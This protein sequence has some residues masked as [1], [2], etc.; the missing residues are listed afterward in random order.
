MA[1]AVEGPQNT[2]PLDLCR[3]Q[4]ETLVSR[5]LLVLSCHAQ[6]IFQK[7]KKCSKLSETV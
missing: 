6:E 2:V 1:L 7:F 4:M 3:P 5:I